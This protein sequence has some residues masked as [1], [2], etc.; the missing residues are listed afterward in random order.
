MAQIKANLHGLD[1]PIISLALIRVYLR[2]SAS[3]CG[4]GVA[5]SGGCDFNCSS[6]DC[7]AGASEPLGASLR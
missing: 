6:I 3:I 1:W 2:L 4:Q 7:T 5:Q